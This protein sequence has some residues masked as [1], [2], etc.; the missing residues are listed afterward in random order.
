MAT[1]GACSNSATE[2]SSSSTSTASAA[3]AQSSSAA[4]AAPHNQADMMFA[5]MMIPHHQQAVE[6]S[7][8]ILAKQGIDPR[9]VDLANQ[10]KAAQGPEIA[11]MEGWL[12]QWG[13]QMSGTPGMPGTSGSP[14]APPSDHGGMHGSDTAM[15]GMD[16]MPGMGDMAGM[17]G[18]MSPADMQ[19][20]QNA[21]GV[22][23][24]KLFL[25]QMIEHHR[26][27]ITMA[28]NEIKNGQSPDAVAL[29][30]SIATSQQKEIDTMNQ[31]LS[32]L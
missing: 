19:A 15:P 9:V 18:M 23:A 12:Q 31:I 28:Q 4:P 32:S 1:I 30:K 17:E 5:R 10:I 11:Q 6:M 13:M 7:D 2:Q 16:D 25:T 29:A 20:L 22:E 3:P 8:M 27:A 14:G 21:Q 24:S 26:G